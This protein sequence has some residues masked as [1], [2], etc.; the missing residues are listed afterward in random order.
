MSRQTGHGVQYLPGHVEPFVDLVINDFVP[1]EGEILDL[2]GGGLRFGLPVARLGRRVTVVDVD[3]TGLDVEMVVQ[4]VN[5]NEGTE[6]DPGEITPL[7]DLIECD[8]LDFLRTNRRE[9][10]LI[11][12]FR[13]AHFMD[14]DQVAELFRSTYRA[15]S[16]GGRFAFSAMTPYNLPDAAELNEVYRWTRPV[17]ENYP[18]FRVFL[19][20]PEADQVRQSQNLGRHVHVVD[21]EWV[22]ARARETG[23]DVL[24]DGVTATR[25]V[26]GF[27]MGKP[28]R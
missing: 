10:A 2:G 1:D 9:F 24:I 6:L 23:Y 20:D 5:E 13:V 11:T 12:A 19:D 16:F 3:P 25:I 4:R 15:S 26:A 28:D 7:L 14:P 8:A 21:S 27:V 22:A 18:Y 17:A